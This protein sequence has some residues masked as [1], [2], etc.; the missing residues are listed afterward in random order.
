M[1]PA[2]PSPAEAAA[3]DWANTA[4]EAALNRVLV[5]RSDPRDGPVAF[6][7]MLNGV[8]R[9]HADLRALRSLIVD[10]EGADL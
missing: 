1:T 5:W 8:L 6:F 7:S 3:K 10:L 2:P 9:R 4:A